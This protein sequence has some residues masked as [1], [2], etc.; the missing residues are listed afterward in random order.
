MKIQVYPKAVVYLLLFQL[1]ITSAGYAQS[2]SPQ[3]CAAQA[4][5]AVRERGS[6]DA[7]MGVAGGAVTGAA[8][9]AIVGDSSRAAGRGALFGAIVGGANEASQRDRDY[10]RAYRRCMYG[11]QEMR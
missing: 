2:P 3:D 4:E 9:G 7:V 6:N 8:F 5:Y 1:M 11:L 10:E